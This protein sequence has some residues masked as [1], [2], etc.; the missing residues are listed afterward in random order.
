MVMLILF[1]L[2]FTLIALI[3]FS[4][5]EA[6]DD[7]RIFPPDSLPY[8]L[9]YGQW[10]A[11][12][13]QWAVS[14]PLDKSPFDDPT[15]ERC[16]TSQHDPKVW[17]LAGTSGGEATRTCQVPAGKGIMFT[18][19][20]VRCDYFVD[21]VSKTDDDL[22]KCAKDDQDTVNVLNATVDG[23]AIQ[24]LDRF[25]VQSPLFNITLPPNNIAGVSPGTTQAI[26]DGWFII[27]KPLQVGEHEIRSYG[28]S[29]DPTG[30]GNIN[31]ATSTTFKII[32]K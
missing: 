28:A 22:R 23:K 1:T 12:W 6:Q 9:T 11:K 16:G 14:I 15:G 27:L 4:S 30:S 17:F 31:F 29:I 20:N 3:S 24:H 2:S 7:P 8:N 26:S 25:R 19:I 32:V 18:V 13:W 5:I 21:K 10:S